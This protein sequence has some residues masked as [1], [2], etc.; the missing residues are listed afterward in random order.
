MSRNEPTRTRR[1]QSIKYVL[2]RARTEKTVRRAIAAALVLL[3]AAAGIYEVYSLH[4]NPI[5]TLTAQEETASDSVRAEAF[6]LRDEQTF[7][8]SLSGYTVPFVQDGER[9]ESNAKIAARFSD[10]GS[11]Q[12]FS[13]LREMREE[14]ARYLALSAGREY[15]SMKV[16]TLMQKAADGMCA[17]LQQTDGGNVLASKDSET[18]YLDRET[19]LEIAVS[20]SI[21]LTDKLSELSQNIQAQ[22]ATV[23]NYET[24]TTG[25][26]AA[27]FFF[28]GTDGFE[29]TLSFADAK[30]LTAAQIEKALHAKASSTSG[31]KIVKSHA[32]YITALV[33]AQTADK[34]SAAQG[35][36]ML[37]IHFPQAGVQDVQTSVYSIKKQ[38]DGK[39]A[40]VFRCIETNESLLRLRKVEIDIV[41]G[42]KTG[43]RIPVQA[44]RVL[45]EDG[46]TV[47][48]VYVLRGNIVTFRRLNVV[49][50]GEEYL[51]SAPKAR[52]STEKY[53]YVSLY[54]EIITGGKN[55]YNGALVY[56]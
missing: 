47:R 9:V 50:S 56:A 28:S 32:W 41:L 22:E 45:E 31:C 23:G 29:D 21:D 10:A 2:Q 18:D 1:R 44:V 37:R 49:Y 40:V 7:D 4:Q 53:A 20:G 6:V 55:L 12:R 25:V 33:D 48:G 51:L 14:Y 15:S 17:F 42:E 30:E 52:E 43:F 11:A 27:G 36:R 19:A 8:V 35:K 39:C 24:V 38:S 16:E 54:D 3:V 13:Q 46:K 34:L 26:E 5:R